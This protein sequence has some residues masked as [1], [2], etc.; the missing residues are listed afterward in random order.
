MIIPS[1]W[2]SHGAITEEIHQI[3]NDWHAIKSTE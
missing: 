3:D 1:K 2:N